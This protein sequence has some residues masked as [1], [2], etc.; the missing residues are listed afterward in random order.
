MDAVNC[1]GAT[2][3]VNNIVATLDD[4]LPW[5]RQ[6]SQLRQSKRWHGGSAIGGDVDNRTYKTDLAELVV[7]RSTYDVKVVK[8]AAVKIIDN[9]NCTGATC[10]VDNIVA[11][12]TIN[13][14]GI[15][16]V[17]SYVKV[18][19][20]QEG[21][22]TGGDVDNRTYKTDVAV[23]VV[24]QD[25]YDVRII[26]G[27]QAIIVDAVN[28]NAAACQINDIVATL[29]I[30]FPGISSVHTYVKVNDNTA[31]TAS[32]GDVD[33][34]TYKTDAVTLAVLRT[35]Y[36]V[37]IVKGASVY[38]ADAV[39]CT[40]ATLSSPDIV[41]TLTVNSPGVSHV[42]TYIKLNDGIPG[43][44]NGADVDNR[45]YKAIRSFWQYCAAYDVRVV[46][47]SQVN[48]FD[49]VNCTGATCEINNMVTGSGTLEATYGSPTVEFNT[50]AAPVGTFSIVY[51]SGTGH[52]YAG[53]VV[54]GQ[55]VCVR[56]DGNTAYVAGK[57]TASNSATW[58]VNQY[59]RFG[60]QDGGTDGLNYTVGENGMPDCATFTHSAELPLV[61]GDFALLP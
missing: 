30:E 12:L 2:C 28:C 42:H 37:R 24:L 56:F 27:A 55:V 7:L 5:H 38:I 59:V 22:A 43:T 50:N 51:P 21:S 6:C 44:A 48:I 41:A 34:R 1:N 47:G 40:G 32:G 29:T 10:T 3:T 16:S 17:H 58:L 9:V 61:A 39:N 14:P 57:V 45:T 53:A 15:A 35:Y 54:S 46:K 8:G 26:K 11:T 25:V 23:L 33:N 13:F 19:D 52:S 18:N 20:G 4:Q 60:V 31:N 36:D 49:A